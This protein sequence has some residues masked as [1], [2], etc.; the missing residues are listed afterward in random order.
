MEP[1]E[2]LKKLHPNQFSDS[3][4]IEKVDCPREILDF[5]ISNLSEHNMHFDFEDLIRKLME[6]EVCPNLIEETGPAAGGDGKVDTENYPVS[7]SLQK[8]WYYGNNENN[9]KW[10]FAISLKKRWKEKCNL[11]IGKIIKTDRNY[12]KIF[13]VTNQSIP[14]KKRLE[15]QDQKIKETGIDIIIYDKNWILDKLLKD[16]NIDL[17]KEL[18]ISTPL[19]EK[20]IGPNDLKK[21]RRKDEIEKQLLDFAQKKKLNQKVVDLTFESA[22]ISRDLEEDESVVVGKFERALRLAQEKGNINIQKDILYHLA[23]YYHWWLNSDCG[24]EKY[25][26]LYEQ[27]V[28]KEK[29][30]DDVLNLSNLWILAYTRQKGIKEKNENLEIKTHNIL[31]S[32]NELKKSKSKVVQ[33]EATSRECMIKILLNEDIDEQFKLLLSITDEAAKFKEFDFV[34]LAKMIENLLEVYNGNCYYDQLY[35]LIIEKLSN[36]SSDIQ[37]AEMYLKK[38]KLLSSNGEKY[39]AITLLGKC[40]TLLY[41]EE[42]NGKLVEAYINIGANFE[43]IGLLYAAKNYYISAIALFMDI[44]LKDDDLDVFSLK[45]LDRIIGLEIHFGNIEESIEWLNI[46]NIFLRILID[47]N[48]PYDDELEESTLEADALI[49]SQILDT[50]MMNFKQLDKIIYLCDKNGLIT[51]SVMAN[52]VLGNYD[53]EL[54]KEHD[55]NK[56]LVDN[57]ILEFYK[58]SRI[59]NIALPVYNDEQD[60]TLTSRVNGNKIEIYFK[61]SKILK[62]FA[63]FIISLLENTFATMFNCDAYMRGDIIIKIQEKN[64]GSFKADYTFDGIDTFSIVIDTID[65]YDVSIENHKIITDMLFKLLGHIF[66]TSFIYKD[67]TIVFKQLFEDDKT[68][69]RALNHTNSIYNLNKIFG[70][71]NYDDVPIHKINRDTEWN[72]GLEIEL[73][74][75][76][77]I[78]VCPFDEKENIIHASS[79][80]NLFKNVSHSNIY[81]SDMIKCNHWDVAKWKGVMYLGDI[82]Y[83]YFIRIG[84]IFENEEGAKKVFQDIINVSTKDDIN[85]KVILSFIK[86][87]DK[88]APYDYRIMITE[89]IEIPK[90]INDNTLISMPTRFHQMNCTD[91]KNINILEQI[92]CSGNP[93]IS[94]LP[95]FINN[96][97]LV[98]LNDYEI[99]IKKISI[100]NAYEIGINDIESFAILP[101]D[102]PIIPA[103]VSIV[104]IQE[105]LKIK[106]SK[107]MDN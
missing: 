39:D 101:N 55:N 32:L 104:P 71:E 40:L 58:Q 6:R 102:D 86:G 62:R 60:K 99:L 73:P 34:V 37:K 107:K 81:S 8:F 72:L 27:D 13:F 2:L 77:E 45:V 33:L 57:Q 23:W 64:T 67:E 69:E 94:I 42:S 47:K 1:K 24:F 16:S 84:F 3:K 5:K 15:Y 20:Q 75:K 10:A 4:I 66:A 95:I 14:N 35:D 53:E 18:N 28:L 79:P 103:D 25:Y 54:L 48:E 21:Q 106:K 38:S 93:K 100:K 88:K 46:K 51:S 17:V 11:D 78:K 52:Y 97:K 36:R 31:D 70:N 12:K 7:T 44:F 89:K 65:L 85:E 9:E 92:M 56:E 80:G 43:S 49:A 26:D 83:K 30:L 98:P 87:V 59:L 50:K 96:D 29:R 76:D 91:N 41:K 61:G 68:F 19:I 82:E 74:L 63:E 90:G 22:I 105:L